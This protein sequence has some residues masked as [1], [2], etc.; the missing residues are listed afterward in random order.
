MK[1]SI[2]KP[3]LTIKYTLQIAMMCCL[4]FTTALSHANEKLPTSKQQNVSA[5]AVSKININTA[6]AVLISNTL[7]GIG[8]K[9][10]EAIVEYRNTYGPFK[11]IDE[12]ASVSGIGHATIK[13]NVHLIS[14]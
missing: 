10:A 14:I 7:K 3:Y 4:L 6:E 9:K 12:L 5:P 2:K 13:K 1:F 8:M 11:T